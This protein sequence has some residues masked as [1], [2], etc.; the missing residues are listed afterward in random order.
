LASD[1]S[2]FSSAP[3][4]PLSMR[5][6]A[7]DLL[8]LLLAGLRGS[9]SCCSC[10]S[11]N[12]TR[13]SIPRARASIFPA[14]PHTFAD[15]AANQTSLQCAPGSGSEPLPPSVL[16]CL[17]SSF[18]L[19]LLCPFPVP[20]LVTPPLFPPLP[21]NPLSSLL[22]ARVWRC[23]CGFGGCGAHSL[24]KFTSKTLPPSRS[25]SIALHSMLLARRVSAAAIAAHLR[26]TPVC[27]CFCSFS[28]SSSPSLSPSSLPQLVSL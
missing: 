6:R 16:S 24:S 26:L 23:D 21:P 12:D 14:A 1:K 10:C 17:C 27:A 7:D 20:F 8:L 25:L 15:A 9:C 18:C 4:L 19:L 2:T 13:C 5:S 28:S 22:V 11:I 3:P